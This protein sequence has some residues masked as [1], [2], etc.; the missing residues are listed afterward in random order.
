MKKYRLSLIVMYSMISVVWAD[1]KVPTYC[2][3]DMKLYIADP[4]I[5]KHANVYYLYGTS[6]NKGFLVYTSTDLVHWT[7]PAGS[8]NGFCLLSDNSWGDTNF[9]APK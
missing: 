8:D 1:V 4:F 9:W 2:N 7:G 3:A 6:S 5:L